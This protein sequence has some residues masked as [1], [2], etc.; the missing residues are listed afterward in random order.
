MR[1]EWE[2][3]AVWL[4]DDKSNA[5]AARRHKSLKH[6]NIQLCI[7]H[8]YST[9]IQPQHIYVCTYVYSAA[10]TKVTSTHKLPGRSTL[11][12]AYAY[13]GT[14]NTDETS[15][16]YYNVA[17]GCCIVSRVFKNSAHAKK[18]IKLTNNKTKRTK[19]QIRSRD[20][21]KTVDHNSSGPEHNNWL[22]DPPSGSFL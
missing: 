11:W 13:Y 6:K 15:Q 9:L 8:V 1:G 7:Y 17:L 10:D 19:T 2:S 20:I 12:R 21:V 18:R 3:W 22:Q 14:C 5:N 4:M 16:K